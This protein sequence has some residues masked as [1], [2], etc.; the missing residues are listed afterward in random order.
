MERRARRVARKRDV[1]SGGA[2][3]VEHRIADVDEELVGENLSN[4][5]E[6]VTVEADPAIVRGRQIVAV[7]LQVL[8]GIRSTGA[9]AVG[10]ESPKRL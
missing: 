10:Q 7:D 2:H 1:E 8:H 3:L 5:G 9:G 6:I 4:G